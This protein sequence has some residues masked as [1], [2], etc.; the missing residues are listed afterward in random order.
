MSDA[1]EQSPLLSAAFAYCHHVCEVCVCVFSPT[2]GAE[3]ER[4]LGSSR[5]EPAST[6]P[7]KG[8]PGQRTE[9]PGGLCAAGR[10][11][12]CQV[13]S[14]FRGFHVKVVLRPTG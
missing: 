14:A 12:S 4:S 5:A 2:A 3:P 7:V 1:S 11:G 10:V 8:G 6:G 9:C 13:S